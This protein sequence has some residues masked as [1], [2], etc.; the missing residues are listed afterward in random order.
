MRIEG[1][2]R[3]KCQSSRFPRNNPCL[4]TFYLLSPSLRL[5]CVPLC[6][7]IEQLLPSTSSPLAVFLPSS[8]FISS[9]SSSSSPTPS[10]SPQLPLN[11]LSFLYIMK[12]KETDISMCVSLSVSLSPSLSIPHLPYLSS[13]YPSSAI[14]FFSIP[15]LPSLSSL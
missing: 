5:N 13:L 6:A 3:L 9:S 14:S 7:G 4:L 10:P 15:P 12:S 2:E 11:C 8:S 1:N